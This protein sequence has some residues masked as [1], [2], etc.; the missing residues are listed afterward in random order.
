MKKFDD[1][2]LDI[3]TKIENFEYKANDLLPSEHQL[4]ETYGVSRETVRKALQLLLEHGYIQ[5]KQGKGSI[6]L[7]RRQFNFSVSGLTSFK[8][9]QELQNMPSR[10]KVIENKLMPAPD[11]LVE[12]GLV[13]RKDKVIKL[14]RQRIVNQDIVIVDTDYINAQ[15]VNQL[16]THEMEVSLYRYLEEEHGL[17][18]A[19]AKK[20]VTVEP[21]TEFDN[22]YM[23][24]DA[25][26]HVVVVRGQV[27]L[28]D[29]QFIQYTESRHRLDK[30]KFIDFARRMRV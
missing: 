18:I 22:L 20:E 3:K 21:L 19:Y 23:P 14:I 6:V 27:F 8:E 30:F 5:K 2:Y 9:L 1:I 29:T 17:Q 15:L 24:E 28:E 11:F 25:N 10:T 12:M 16:P 13:S 4:T 26:T 7:D